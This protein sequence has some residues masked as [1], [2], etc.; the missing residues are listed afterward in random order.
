M[1]AKRLLKRFRAERGPMH[2]RLQY[3][4]ALTDVLIRKVAPGGMV[5]TG[6]YIPDLNA[7]V[8][9]MVDDCA[10][11]GVVSARNDVQGSLRFVRPV[12]AAR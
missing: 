8:K 9:I 10:V 11:E 12:G 6:S 4:A 3:G 1:D 2:A 5:F 7:M